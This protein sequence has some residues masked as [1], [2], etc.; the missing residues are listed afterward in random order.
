[1][2]R[3]QRPALP[4]L[5]AALLLA[6]VS[7]LLM[8]AITPEC[9][10]AEVSPPIDESALS[11]PSAD[12][13]ASAD[14]TA[15]TAP[16]S[17]APLIVVDAGH[18][19]I[20]SN[21]NANHLREKNVN[22]AIAQVL[23]D[24]L[25]A[26]GYRVIMTRNTDRAITYADIATW[27]WSSARQSW[28]F[29]RD[30]DRFY[31]PSIPEDDLQARVNIANS[32]GADLFIS[33]HANGVVSRRARGYET[34]AS[35]RDS[36]G[37][38]A[39][40]AVHRYVI[41]RTGLHDRT[42]QRSDFYVLR[43]SNMPAF[44]IESAF[45]TNPSDA[46]LLKQA[47]F[48]RR[49]AAAVADGVAAWMRT[50]PYRASYPR[51]SATSTASF[52]STV[53]ETTDTPA[54]TAVL[55]REDQ[56]ADAPG[57]A[58]YAASLNAPL[59]FC[60]P[61][62]PSSETARTLGLLSPERVVLIGLTNAFESTAAAEV[63]AACGVEQ[64]AVESVSAGSRTELAAL[65]A[66]RMAVGSSGDILVADSNDATAALAA[67]GVAAT[68]K[69]PLLLADRGMLPMS[70]EAYLGANPTISRVVLAGSAQILPDFAASG[71]RFVRCQG[72]STIAVAAALNTAVVTAPSYVRPIVAD[73]SDPSAYLVSATRAGRLGQTIVPVEGQVLSSAMRLWI[74]NRRIAIRGF[75]I[76]D[77]HRTT[78]P[79]VDV[80]LRKADYY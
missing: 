62:G 14:A 5:I 50:R 33:V 30:H 75:E 76:H 3:N 63:A 25:V 16:D 31:S 78:P 77:P 52:C 22:L 47:W 17:R 32:A 29:G 27:N 67:A 68:F 48:R 61:S 13:I 74:T 4:G 54:S 80:M 39:R 2:P 56:C 55:I 10:R 44:L 35:S 28:W 6:A 9:A 59:L 12:M 38:T 73:P 1:M 60:G 69:T 23:R 46:Y 19:G 11:S 49:L 72:T 66:S 20:Y 45:I 7:G 43:W 42:A 53:A 24:A 51:I 40:S 65:I 79:L 41:R 58:A 36:L 8:A 18:G 26:R 15:G 37:L 70:V 71:R 57:A 64:R 34:F 21:A